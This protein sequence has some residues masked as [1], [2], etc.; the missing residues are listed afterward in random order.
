V[1]KSKKVAFLA[2]FKKKISSC[3]PLKNTHV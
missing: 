1:E 2:G 3:F